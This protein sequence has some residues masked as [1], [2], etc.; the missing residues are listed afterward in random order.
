MCSATMD[1]KQDSADM[2][3]KMGDVHDGKPKS[4]DPLATASRLPDDPSPDPTGGFTERF[5]VM[6]Q[7]ISIYFFK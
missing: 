1:T 5:I 6:N 2:N 3:G 4:N 7:S